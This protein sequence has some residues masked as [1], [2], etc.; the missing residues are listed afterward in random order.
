MPSSASTRALALACGTLPTADLSAAQPLRCRPS[1]RL[2]WEVELGSPARKR[3]PSTWNV[4]AYLAQR[5]TRV[6]EAG[7]DTAMASVPNSRAPVV[8]R[9]AV[10]GVRSC[11]LFREQAQLDVAV[12]DGDLGH[13]PLGHLPLAAAHATPRSAERLLGWGAGCAGQPPLLAT[14]GGCSGCAGLS[15]AATACMPSRAAS[16]APSAAPAAPAAP[17]G[18]SPLKQTAVSP[19]AASSSLNP[20]SSAWS[21]I[22]P[23][24]SR[25]SSGSVALRLGR[26][27]ALRRPLRRRESEGAAVWSVWDTGA[28]ILLG[29]CRAPNSNSTP[30][31]T[32]PA[33]SPSATPPPWP[34]PSS[35]GGAGAG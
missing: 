34:C 10:V 22:I 24:Q 35:G 6:A 20:S 5:Q 13:L 27:G 26:S 14:A 30:L 28:C 2:S 23:R 4:T 32:H 18:P 33:P 9:G 21:C 15:S 29:P 17:A 25:S 19:C 3:N 8:Q 31:S 16:R 12:L 1:A 11:L 7:M